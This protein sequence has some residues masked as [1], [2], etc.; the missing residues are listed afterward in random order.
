[1]AETSAIINPDKM[2]LLPELEAGCNLAD[3]I[4]PAGLKTVKKLYPDAELPT[5]DCSR[6]EHSLTMLYRSPRCLAALAEGLIQG[7]ADHF[8]EPIEIVTEDLSSGKGEVV[9]FTITKRA[10]A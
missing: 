8:R 5:F 9:R 1:M 2:T 3:D 10:A 4:T 6:T 7:C